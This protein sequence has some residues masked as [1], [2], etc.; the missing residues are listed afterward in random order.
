[1]TQPDNTSRAYELADQ[2][3]SIILATNPEALVTKPTPTK[4]QSDG[5]TTEFNFDGALHSAKALAEFRQQLANALSAQH[6]TP[7]AADED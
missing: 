1:M 2:W 6:F 4:F 3:I 7:P 5:R